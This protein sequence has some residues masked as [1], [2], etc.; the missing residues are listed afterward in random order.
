MREFSEI[1]AEVVGG[2]A[3]AELS[4]EDQAIFKGYDPTKFVPVDARDSAAAAARKDEADK[5]A[6]IQAKLEESQTAI[7][8]LTKKLEDKDAN[9]GTEA[10]QMK[11]NVEKLRETV[12]DLSTKLEASNTK[13]AESAIKTAR[14]KLSQGMPWKQDVYDSD[15]AGTITDRAFA[16]LSAE[17]L[18][19]DA[20]TGP[21]LEK[22]QEDHPSFFAADVP[23][24]NGSKPGEAGGGGSRFKI[25][26]GE[27]EKQME[28]LEPE[29]SQELLNKVNEHRAAGTLDME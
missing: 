1:M 16:D 17:D 8:D 18:Q 4:E 3:I 10:E 28:T 26:T 19:N 14:G 11:K 2:K 7:A 21:I 13:I 22:L 29:K 15:F 6:K 5:A 12:T 25:S 9:T 23:S 24:G 20:I 27:F